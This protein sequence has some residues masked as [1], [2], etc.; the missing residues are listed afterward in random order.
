MSSAQ[1]RV[2]LYQEAITENDVE[3]AL[4]RAI[5]WVEREFH[6]PLMEDY[7]LMKFLNHLDELQWYRKEEEKQLRKLKNKKK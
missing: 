7:P 6:F 4:S 5:F 2:K 1:L 3:V